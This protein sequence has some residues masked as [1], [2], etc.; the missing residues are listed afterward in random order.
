MVKAFY[1]PIIGKFERLDITI[2]IVFLSI[3]FHPHQTSPVKGE[4]IL[5]PSP[6]GRDQREGDQWYLEF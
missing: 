1:K 3:I 6:G 5:F 2:K 4:A